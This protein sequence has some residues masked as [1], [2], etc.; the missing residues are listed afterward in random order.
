MYMLH[1]VFDSVENGDLVEIS[2]EGQNHLH[3]TRT[4][5]NEVYEIHTSFVS[6]LFLGERSI[7]VQMIKA[8]ADTK[9]Q[10]TLDV[11]KNVT[12]SNQTDDCVIVRQVSPLELMITINV[13]DKES[14]IKQIYVGAGS[15]RE[16]FQ[17]HP[18][19]LVP[20]LS[21]VILF[22]E[23]PHGQAIYIT[24][25]V[26][27]HAGIRGHFH[28]HA[29][30]MDHTPPIIS[31]AVMNTT[32]ISFGEDTLTTVSVTWEVIDAESSSTHCSC[33][34]V[35]NNSVIIESGMRLSLH[36]FQ[37]P[38]LPLI[39]G[40]MISAEVTC[41]NDAD[42]KKILSVGPKLI[43]Y[44]PPDIN[45]AA[46]YV[47]TL[48]ETSSEVPVIPPGS[49][50]IFSWGEF[51]DSYGIQTYSYRVLQGDQV[52]KDWEDTEMRTY[53]SVEDVSL[54]NNNLYIVEVTA[55]SKDGIYSK[56]IN[57]SVLVT[58][59]APVLT[60]R[61]SKVTRTGEKIEIIW[62]DVF[63]VRPELLP[64][65]A[66]KLGSQEGLVDILRHIETREQ[67]HVFHNTYDGSDV[68]IDI[69]CK[70]QTGASSVF[71]EKQ[72]LS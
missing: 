62:S 41:S 16:G 33:A 38:Y 72:S 3:S 44:F 57:A 51:D 65:Y 54:K 12:L 52:T 11:S 36:H 1:L 69:T 8:V 22:T 34:I 68:F 45:N 27:N 5:S 40:S 31:N 29:I 48:A 71:R 39:H 17:I 56:A 53:V 55:C 9:L 6:S 15:T 60:G 37:T 35:V 50:L 58:G 43:T 66:I 19:L 47:N 61:H 63:S 70:Y 32:Y 20:S 28:S 64:T 26:E 24:A 2:F 10:L 14:G 7:T 25:I 59:D 30:I 18:L 42:L 23:A 13:F 67:R 4:N 49:P 21:N 46:I